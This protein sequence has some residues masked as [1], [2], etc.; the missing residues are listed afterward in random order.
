MGARLRAEGRRRRTKRDDA[1]SYKQQFLLHFASFNWPP[2]PRA[3]YQRQ[4]QLLSLQ[5][6][7]ARESAACRNRKSALR[8]RT[9]AEVIICS[10]C[11]LG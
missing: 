6:N 1:R 9:L 8:A 4:L 2:W 11:M 3:S 7:T 10:S 5:R